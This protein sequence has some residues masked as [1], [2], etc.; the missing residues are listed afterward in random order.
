MPSP[1]DCWTIAI[2]RQRSVLA[3][4]HQVKKFCSHCQQSLPLP[5]SANRAADNKC[6]PIQ[7]LSDSNFS[8]TA[9]SGYVSP[10]QGTRGC[11]THISTH[12]SCPSTHYSI[13][14][15]LTTTT[16]YC[17]SSSWMRPRTAEKMMTAVPSLTTV[18]DLLH[19]PYNAVLEQLLVA[20][21]KR[22]VS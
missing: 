2:L 19:C 4:F 11:A 17:W 1:F 15:L 22:I 20:S 12:L 9:R 3:M 18:N 16:M 6:I 10:G 7:L 13:F 5:A 8:T 14:L 21:P